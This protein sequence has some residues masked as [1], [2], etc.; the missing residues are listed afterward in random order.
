MDVLFEGILNLFD[1]VPH[2]DFYDS[3]SGELHLV[4]APQD[5]AFPY[6]V[7]FLVTHIHDWM[8]DPEEYEIIRIQF[9]AHSKD[10]S[11]LEITDICNKLIAQ[12]DDCEDSMTVAG[13]NVVWFR[14]FSTIFPKPRPAGN[15][16]QVSVT[17]NV[18][19]EKSD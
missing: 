13:Y 12:F 1:T 19:L 5:T 14:R 18:L 15:K 10:T 7:F 6:V 8:F 17:Y 2:S 11:G 3:I 9:N 4:D 16:W